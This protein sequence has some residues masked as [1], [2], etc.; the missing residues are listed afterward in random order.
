MASAIPC[1]QRR[2][3]L[4]ALFTQ[5][6]TGNA[7]IGVAS[8]GAKYAVIDPMFPARKKQALASGDMQMLQRFVGR[9]GSVDSLLQAAKAQGIRRAV[10]KRAL[11]SRERYAL[12]EPLYSLEGRST[13]FDVFQFG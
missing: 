3:L 7:V 11:R 8:W 12:L 9:G 5:D 4:R 1:S 10:V 13:R 2:S 6:D